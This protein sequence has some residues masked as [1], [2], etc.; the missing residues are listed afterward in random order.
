[1]FGGETKIRPPAH[2]ARWSARLTPAGQRGEDVGGDG[3]RDERAALDRKH[4]VPNQSEGGKRRYHGS[5][6]DETCYAESGQHRGISV[7]IHT[8]P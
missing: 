1:M 7:G 3:K 2:R 8:R 6:S 5:K 4:R